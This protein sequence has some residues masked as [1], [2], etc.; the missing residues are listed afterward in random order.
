[1][2]KEWYYVFRELTSKDPRSE[3]GY[4]LVVVVDCVDAARPL[5]VVHV[6]ALGAKEAELA[7]RAIRS[8]LL[9]MERLL[10]HTI[11]VRTRTRLHD[12]KAELQTLLKDVDC[13][14]TYL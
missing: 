1:V 12:L 4:K 8:E 11:Y 14:F 3:V 6:P 5:S 9:S 13:G 7:D 2:L 10:V